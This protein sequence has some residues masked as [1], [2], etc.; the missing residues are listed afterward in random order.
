[1]KI[2]PVLTSCLIIS[3]AYNVYQFVDTNP[4]PITCPTQPG[5]GETR[6][7]SAEDA[8]VFIEQYQR[9]LQGEDI[10]WGG[11]ITR[12]SF[13]D[14][15]CTKECNAIAYEFARDN[16]GKTG[17]PGNGVFTF[18]TAVNVQYENGNITTVRD[19][20]LDRYFTRNWCPPSCIP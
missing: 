14:I 8:R 16:T 20:G 1:M 9:S 4:D 2:I 15:L 5:F 10:T 13:D 12:K 3:V 18:F 11:I 7:L 17:P 6:H 19:L